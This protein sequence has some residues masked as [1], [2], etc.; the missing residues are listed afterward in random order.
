MHCYCCLCC[1]FFDA[2]YYRL[3]R[4]QYL[5]HDF[6]SPFF[7]EKLCIF[8][9][10][11]SVNPCVVFYCLKLLCLIHWI[12]VCKRIKKRQQQHPTRKNVEQF[13][14]LV[15]PIVKWCLIPTLTYIHIHIRTIQNCQMLT[16]NIT[17]HD[18]SNL[19]LWFVS[20]LFVPL[21][22]LY[23]IFPRIW[24]KCEKQ[25]KTNHNLLAFRDITA[26]QIIKCFKRG[27]LKLWCMHQFSG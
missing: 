14:S 10:F 7:S 12:Q 11:W 3:N 6:C 9:P 13:D 24:N 5:Y 27:I 22:I 17:E 8:F 2:F 16:M 4:D 25:N 15:V 26:I 21:L 1:W 23:H 20:F 18:F 19:S